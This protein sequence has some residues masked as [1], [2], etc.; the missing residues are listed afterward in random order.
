M[1]MLKKPGP[2]L[3][4][5]RLSSNESVGKSLKWFSSLEKRKDSSSISMIFTF[6]H[7]SYFLGYSLGHANTYGLKKVN[8]ES[9]SLILLNV[10]PLCTILVMFRLLALLM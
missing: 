8:S 4:S 7:L 9:K 10:R 2:I 6:N 1:K 5:V 3:V